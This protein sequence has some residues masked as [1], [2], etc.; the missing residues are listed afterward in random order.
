MHQSCPCG[1]NLPLTGCC[2]PYIEGKKT[3]PTAEALLRSRY[4]SFVLAT[5][6]SINYI[7]ETHH[8]KTRHEVNRDE[9]EKWAK[10]SKWLGLKILNVEAGSEKDSQG[11]ITF[12]AQYESDGQM[13]NHSER[14]LFEKENGSW[15][16]LDAQSLAPQA[17]IRRTEPKL[18]RN[19]PC[20]CGS[21]KKFKKCCAA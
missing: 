10:D 20:A 7:L 14:S 11:L 3:A 9:I 15:K 5:D 13:N 12:Q 4:C 2:L 17:P 16:F 8:S 6:Q 1:S 21:G 19:D 18:G